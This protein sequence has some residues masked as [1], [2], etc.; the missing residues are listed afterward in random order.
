ML[1]RF[2]WRLIN[3]SL[4]S[5]ITHVRVCESFLLSRARAAFGT[6]E[7]VESRQI[8]KRTNGKVCLKH[9]ISCV[10]I[11]SWAGVTYKT[12]SELDDWI[13]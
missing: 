5:D 6:E 12:G 9:C 8:L 3:F 2:N 11:V 10:I 1:A 4:N 13:Y 7:E